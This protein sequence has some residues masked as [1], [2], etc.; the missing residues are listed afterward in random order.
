MHVP[1]DGVCAED[2]N[3]Y[4]DD[5]NDITNIPTDDNEFSSVIL[6]CA[7]CQFYL[8]TQAMKAELLLRYPNIDGY[9]NKEHHIQHVNKSRQSHSG[10]PPT[11]MSSYQMRKKLK[12]KYSNKK[13][14]KKSL[15]ALTCDICEQTF[16]T[17]EMLSN[18]I[19]THFEKISFQCLICGEDHNDRQNLIE[20][21]PIHIHHQNKEFCESCSKVFKNVETLRI[22]NSKFHQI[23][24]EKKHICSYCKQEFFT[25]G[26]LERHVNRNHFKKQICKYCNKS[27]RDKTHLRCHTIKKHTKEFPFRCH[28]C[29]KG[30]CLPSAFRRHLA[31]HEGKDVECTTCG[32]MI[33]IDGSNYNRHQRQH[34]QEEVTK[35]PDLLFVCD[36]CG[37][38]RQSN[39][40]NKEQEQ[41]SS[42]NVDESENVR[43]L[44]R[45]EK[46]EQKSTENVDESGNVRQSKRRKKEQEQLNC[47]KRSQLYLISFSGDVDYQ[48]QSLNTLTEAL[49]DKEATKNGCMPKNERDI[50]PK[51][52]DI[53]KT[54]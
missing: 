49:V 5:H 35:N 12:R 44:K 18:H 32:K 43:N 27:F 48:V 34:E 53:E 6:K 30:E 38:V 4:S 22:H 13:R 31:E 17:K 33:P 45:M 40:G 28:I 36:I 52:G 2:K 14:G 50:C 21:I 41:K 11:K 51:K 10:K 15:D 42:E 20:H 39:T 26:K 23:C 16:Q 29:G 8:G 37:N 25:K 9:D 54:K 46:E 1:V 24:F 19:P 3:V 47:K 7:R